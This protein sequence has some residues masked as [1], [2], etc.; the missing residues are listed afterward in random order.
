MNKIYFFIF[1]F[2][3]S[4]KLDFR[5]CV[6][7]VLLW[8]VIL[9]ALLSVFKGRRYLSKVVASIASWYIL[10]LVLPS[11]TPFWYIIVY[12]LPTFTIDNVELSL[13]GMVIL[14]PYSLMLV[15]VIGGVFAIAPY[16]VYEKLRNRSILNI[17]G[18]PIYILFIS[19]LAFQATR[20]LEFHL[21]DIINLRYIAYFPLIDLF[22]IFAINSFVWLL[23]ISLTL[24][25][26]GGLQRKKE[27]TEQ[28]L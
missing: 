25:F 20:L 8:M 6:A 17:S 27:I 1:L 4:R 7:V 28:T 9:I 23:W 10:L 12:L 11:L 22:A 16:L 2:V 15:S 26:I 19:F 14:Y 18:I 3:T 21:I 5:V 13:F 24:L